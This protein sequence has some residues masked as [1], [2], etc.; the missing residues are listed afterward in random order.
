MQRDR[1]NY[2]KLLTN[3]RSRNTAPGNIDLYFVTP[4]AFEGSSAAAEHRRQPMWNKSNILT[5]PYLCCAYQCLN[6]K[7]LLWQ[8][9]WI[10][11]LASGI[12]K[13]L[14]MFFSGWQVLTPSGLVF[15]S[16]ATAGLL[17]HEV[18]HTLRPL[19]YFW[20]ILNIFEPRHMIL[21]WKH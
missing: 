17:G 11:F 19:M 7:K 4:S 18:Q 13:M 15:L 6:Q 5:Y 2:G 21:L 16:I 9:F 14:A 3:P 1:E 8:S 12:H 10:C 20:S